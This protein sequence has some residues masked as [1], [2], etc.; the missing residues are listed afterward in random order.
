MSLIGAA[1]QQGNGTVE[2]FKLSGY[3]ASDTAAYCAGSV[4]AV[5]VYTVSSYGNFQSIFD[6]NATIYSD[7]YLTTV[8]DSKSYGDN[9]GARGEKNFDWDSRH[10]IWSAMNVCS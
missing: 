6:D 2:G 1:A 9:P 3:A 7:R 5:D 8:A 10:L 4:T